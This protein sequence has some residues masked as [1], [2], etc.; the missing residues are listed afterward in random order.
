MNTPRPPLSFVDH[1]W[2]KEKVAA[3]YV[4]VPSIRSDAVDTLENIQMGIGRARRA[5]GTPPPP[6]H[7]LFRPNVFM[8][9][10]GWPGFLFNHV[11]PGRPVGAAV[12]GG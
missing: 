1:D 6:A 12:L 9:R 8:W 7:T 10:E 11:K 4:G 2:G 3:Q 5:A